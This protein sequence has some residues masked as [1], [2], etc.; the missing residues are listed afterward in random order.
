MLCGGDDTAR[1]CGLRVD[2]LSVAGSM[3]RRGHVRFLSRF[4]DLSALSGQL[5]ESPIQKTLDRARRILPISE[6]DRN[7]KSREYLTKFAVWTKSIVQI[8]PSPSEF[9]DR[10]GPQ[11]TSSNPIGETSRNAHNSLGI[12]V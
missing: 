2:Q 10:S 6:T 12:L 3:L 7:R 9:L 1:I 4:A 8:P 5:P 11:S